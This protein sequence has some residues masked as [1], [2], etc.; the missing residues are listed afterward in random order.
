MAALPSGADVAV[1]VPASRGWLLLARGD[2][3]ESQETLQR[4]LA[5][6]ESTG[7]RQALEYI[8]VPLAELAVLR[9]QVEDAIAR[10]VPMARQEGGFRVIIESTLAWAYLEKGDLDRAAL[11]SAGSVERARQQ[12]ERLSLADALRVQGMVFDR[13]GD[14]DEARSAFLEAVS[15]ARGMPYPL[16][17][18]RALFELGTME[19]RQGA[20]EEGRTRLK[21]AGEICKRLGARKDLDRTEDVLTGLEG[22]AERP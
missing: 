16:A 2:W 22:L 10:L 17:E 7:D 21:E 5:M 4:A 9:G 6:A 19:I 20:Q 1:Y 8:G 3:D 13:R 18:A 14:R 12:G 15:L 11:L